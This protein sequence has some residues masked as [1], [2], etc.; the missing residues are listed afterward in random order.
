[1][2]RKRV[3][4]YVGGI[5]LA[6][7]V[8]AAGTLSQ[9]LFQETDLLKKIGIL[10]DCFLFP[11][12]LLGGIGALSWAAAEGNFDMLRYGFHMVVQKLLHPLKPTKGFY[13]YKVEREASRHGWLK[14]YLVIGL[15][16]LGASVIC[17]LLYMSMDV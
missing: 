7:A 14:H 16:C 13:E 11:A 15:V 2:D 12:V 8:F 3:G 1:M 4:Q 17:L 6:V 10:S 5:I 9:G